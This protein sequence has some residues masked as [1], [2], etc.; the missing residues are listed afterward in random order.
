MA[1]SSQESQDM[2]VGTV[3]AARRNRGRAATFIL[4]AQAGRYDLAM[5]T[6]NQP[7]MPDLCGVPLDRPAE[8]GTPLAEAIAL[9]R[10]RLKGGT[11]V[12][13]FNSNI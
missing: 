5:S 3:S 11:P 2:Q 10:E 9:Y 12:G 13:A 4:S 6:Q 1:S 8:A 7:A